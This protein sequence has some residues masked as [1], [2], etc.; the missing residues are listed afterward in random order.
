MAQLLAEQFVFITGSVLIGV[1]L[2]IIDH[3]Y[4]RGQGGLSIRDAFL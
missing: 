4:F 1:I 3:K 2:F